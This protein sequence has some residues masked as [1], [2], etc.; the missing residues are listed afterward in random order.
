MVTVFP[1]GDALQAFEGSKLFRQSLGD[2]FVDYLLHLK[3]FEWNRYLNTVS[4][5]E[6]AEYFNLY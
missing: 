6:Q 2:E 3:H 5:W 4:E 1:L